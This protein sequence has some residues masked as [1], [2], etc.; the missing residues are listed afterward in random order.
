MHE[1]CFVF[2]DQ[3]ENFAPSVTAAGCY[4]EFGGKI[5]LLKRNADKSLGD[6]WGIPAGKL[7]EG[8]MPQA[9]LIREVDEEVGLEIVEQDLE[10]MGIVYV[11]RTFADVILHR[12][13]KRFSAL[14]NIRLNLEEHSEARWFTLEEALQLPNITGA[15][16]ALKF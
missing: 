9:V 11:R 16:Q 1:T 7:K 4:C 10:E 12:F 15:V 14:P 3:P 2:L 8:E 6:T 5:L 13:R